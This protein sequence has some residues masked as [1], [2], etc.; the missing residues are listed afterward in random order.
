MDNFFVEPWLLKLTPRRHRFHSLPGSHSGALSAARAVGSG[1]AR[2]RLD[3]RPEGG[4]TPTMTFRCG[5]L[6]ASPG[7][8]RELRPRRRYREHVDLAPDHCERLGP[9]R[10]DPG[11]VVV[12]GLEKKIN[13]LVVHDAGYL[14]SRIRTKRDSSSARP[15]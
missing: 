9:V 5:R 15:G 1:S 13:I 12:D 2:R 6:S 10:Q 8:R 4:P 11:V 14:W 7:G 3:G